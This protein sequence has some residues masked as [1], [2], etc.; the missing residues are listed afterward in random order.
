MDAILCK[1]YLHNDRIVEPKRSIKINDSEDETDDT[2]NDS[3]EKDLEQ[4]PTC[5]S[6][7]EVARGR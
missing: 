4:S 2:A 1:W 6:S 7:K 3:Q 5:S